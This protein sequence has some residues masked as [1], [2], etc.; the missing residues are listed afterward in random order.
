MAKKR[1]TAPAAAKSV[2]LERATRLYQ[3]IQI[4]DTG[5]KSRAALLRKLKID[6]RTFYR[7]L[8]LL[9]ECKIAVA[10]EKR[11]YRLEQDA[12]AALANLP[13]P[14]PGF[15]LGEAKVLA[16]GKSPVHKKLRQMLAAI[17]R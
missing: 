4:L 2:S 17:M 6:I 15:T 14:D 10:L 8:E 16:K 1:V 7:D 12:T 5:P 9:R 3:L 11:T 13:F